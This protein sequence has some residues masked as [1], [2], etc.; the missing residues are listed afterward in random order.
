MAVNV[1][2]TDEFEEWW[3]D[4]NEFEQESIDAVVQLLEEHGPHLVF[5]YSSKIEG[6]KHGH[7]RELRVQHQGNPYRV[8]YAFDPLRNAILLIGGNK[9]GS[10]NWYKKYIPV[11]DRLYDEHLTE[12]ASEK[13]KN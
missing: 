3:K 8:L 4:L 1:E 9:K 13:K 7:M 11:A 5:P 12:L 2:Y 10:D 6:S